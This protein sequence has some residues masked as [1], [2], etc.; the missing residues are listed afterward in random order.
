MVPPSEA[1]L[2]GHIN[3]SLAQAQQQF[4]IILSQSFPSMRGSK[5]RQWPG[6]HFTV[7]KRPVLG[8]SGA[9]LANRPPLET[10]TKTH[11]GG[12]KS[13]GGSVSG[14]DQEQIEKS[15]A[16]KGEN[17]CKSLCQQNA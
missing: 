17:S 7:Q 16:K 14:S 9:S 13:A 12:K 1:C 8:S 10:G 5:A 11:P 4:S 2:Y 6:F 15:P 3:W